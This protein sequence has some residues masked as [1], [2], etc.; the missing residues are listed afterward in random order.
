MED[1]PDSRIPSRLPFKTL[2]HV[3]AGLAVRLGPRL[4]NYDR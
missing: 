2:R 3:H 1:G 4:K